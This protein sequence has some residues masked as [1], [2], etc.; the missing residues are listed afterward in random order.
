MENYVG[1][2]SNTC[3]DNFSLKHTKTI[4]QFIKNFHWQRNHESNYNYKRKQRTIIK[5]NTYIFSIQNFNYSKIHEILLDSLCRQINCD[6]CG[7]TGVGDNNTWEKS[8]V[9]V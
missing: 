4:K 8:S 9:D 1:I 6:G 7:L 5:D 2:I 3:C